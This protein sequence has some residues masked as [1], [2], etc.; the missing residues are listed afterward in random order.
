MKRLTRSREQKKSVRSFIRERV[1]TSVTMSMMDVDDYIRTVKRERPKSDMTENN[2]NMEEDSPQVRRKRLKSED[3][4]D[5][6]DVRYMTLNSAYSTK[7]LE[8]PK[9]GFISRSESTKSYQRPLLR[10]AVQMSPRLHHNLAVSQSF[11]RKRNPQS[12]NTSLIRRLTSFRAKRRYRR[13]PSETNA[14]SLDASCCS[15]HRTRSEILSSSCMSLYNTKQPGYRVISSKLSKVKRCNSTISIGKRREVSTILTF[16]LFTILT[17][18]TELV[19]VSV[20]DNI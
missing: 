4:D 5:L 1:L 9:C 3:V 11:Q 15:L 12:S 10:Y 19:G 2:N 7:Y 18:T 6:T 17:F 8:I 13:L 20:F 16:T 14:Q